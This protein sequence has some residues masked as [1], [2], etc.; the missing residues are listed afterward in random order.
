MRPSDTAERLRKG[1]L[2]ED[3]VKRIE[4]LDALDATYRFVVWNRGDTQ[5][6]V[7]WRRQTNLSCATEE[8]RDSGYFGSDTLLDALEATYF[9]FVYI[10]ETL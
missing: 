7:R 5:L 4:T 6:R 9:V 8:T 10:S 2:I 1:S 3:W